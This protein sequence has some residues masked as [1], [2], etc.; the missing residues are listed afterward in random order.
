MAASS[1]QGDGSTSGSVSKILAAYAHLKPK[2]SKIEQE[3]EQIISESN[4]SKNFKRIIEENNTLRGKLQAQSQNTH[5]SNSISNVN[6]S[7]RNSISA[8]TKSKYDEQIKTYESRIKNLEAL[9]QEQYRLAKIKEDNLNSN[10]EKELTR[11]NNLNSELNEKCELEVQKAADIEQDMSE[12][13]RM[14]EK[15]KHF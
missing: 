3:W 12:L 8:T 1:K 5:L 10:L 13:Q 7:F 9:L 2:I 11:L 6:S 4:I 14:M 15:V